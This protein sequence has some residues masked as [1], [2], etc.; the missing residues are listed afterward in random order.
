MTIDPAYIK[1]IKT[2]LF[3]LFTV[4]GS[5]IFP[6]LICFTLIWP[7]LPDGFIF[8]FIDFVCF[9]AGVACTFWTGMFLA[10][11]NGVTFFDDLILD[12]KKTQPAKYR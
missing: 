3:T 2:I 1:G 7:R 12:D 10:R 4:T 9:L 8:P 6:W 5:L 11:K